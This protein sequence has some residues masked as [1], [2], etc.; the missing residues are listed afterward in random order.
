MENSGIFKIFV[1]EATPR[2]CET[3]KY[4]PTKSKDLPPPLSLSLCLSLSVCGLAEEPL[5]SGEGLC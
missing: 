4:E 2:I 3:I 5:V 1:R